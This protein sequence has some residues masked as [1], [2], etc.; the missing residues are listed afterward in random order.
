MSR[1]ENFNGYAQPLE[2]EESRERHEFHGAV[3]A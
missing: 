3:D 2:R 1:T